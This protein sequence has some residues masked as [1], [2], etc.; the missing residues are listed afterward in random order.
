[1]VPNVPTEPNS[2]PIFAGSSLLDSSD[3][4]DDEY[5]KRISYAKKNKNKRQS[6]MSFNDPIKNCAKLT[7]KQLTAA[8]KSKVVKFKLVEDPQQCRVYLLS[9]ISSFKCLL[10]KFNETYMLL[11]D[12]PSI[13]G[14]DLPGYAKNTTCNLLHAYI[15]SQSQ[16]SIDKYIGNGL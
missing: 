9:F 11:M 14:E 2:D 5:Y 10:S 15:D 3:S 16:I 12:Y 6:K 13:R 8:Y 7:A 4:S 1:M